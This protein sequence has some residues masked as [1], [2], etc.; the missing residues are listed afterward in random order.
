MRRRRG[1]LPGLTLIAVTFKN[2][3][4]T[5][6]YYLTTT[7]EALYL[8]PGA[9]GRSVGRV[10][11][12]PRDLIAQCLRSSRALRGSS[13]GWRCHTKPGSP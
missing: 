2:G 3:E 5:T 4:T 6:G 8:I 11:A 7:P 1:G 13:P 9:F 10:L 12:V